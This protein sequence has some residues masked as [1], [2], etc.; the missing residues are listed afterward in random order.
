MKYSLRNDLKLV[1]SVLKYDTVLNFQ[2]H[3]IYDDICW[4]AKKVSSS[5]KASSSCKTRQKLFDM[6]VFTR[7][8]ILQYK[9]IFGRNFI[10][11]G[12]KVTTDQFVKLLDLKPK[13]EVLDVG[14]GFGG[15]AFYMA[16]VNI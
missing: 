9:A 10:C 6:Q 16:E 12:A 11:T 4:L 15:S 2:N 5:G 7:N 13:Q 3:F 8:V 1:V 14:F